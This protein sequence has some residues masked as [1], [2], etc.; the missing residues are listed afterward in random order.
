MFGEKIGIQDTN[1]ITFG[2]KKIETLLH[3]FWT[4]DKTQNFW[5]SFETWLHSESILSRTKAINKLDALGLK[6]YPENLLLG[7]CKLAA[8]HCIYICKLKE[9]VPKMTSFLHQIKYSLTKTFKKNGDLY[10]S[11]RS[12]NLFK[13]DNMN[14]KSLER[15]EKNKPGIQKKNRQN[16]KNRENAKCK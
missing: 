11:T 9:N 5:I 2:G 10:S 8:R 15:K 1:S 7:F 16:L 6:T 13:N 4:C 3:I 14:I 12:V